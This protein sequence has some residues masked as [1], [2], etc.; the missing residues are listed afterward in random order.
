MINFL[1]IYPIFQ[2]LWITSENH[3]CLSSLAAH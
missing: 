2:N 3:R 1:G